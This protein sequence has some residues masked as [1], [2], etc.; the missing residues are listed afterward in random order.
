MARPLLTCSGS[1]RER[2]PRPA[3]AQ[4]YRDHSRYL[5]RCPERRP[6]GDGGEHGRHPDPD[7][8]LKED[9]DDPW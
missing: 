8:E 2:D 5:H 4:A 6:A 9:I 7:Y 1:Q 3:P